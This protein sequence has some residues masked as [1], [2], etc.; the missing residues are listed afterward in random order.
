MTDDPS[1]WLCSQVQICIASVQGRRNS[2]CV[3]ETGPPPS[4]LGLSERGNRAHD[5]CYAHHHGQTSINAMFPPWQSA[6]WRRD[7]R[8]QAHKYPWPACRAPPRR[9][10]GG[11]QGANW[12]KA[13]AGGPM[14]SCWAHAP[15]HW[16]PITSLPDSGRTCRLSLLVLVCASPSSRLR[17]C[18]PVA[19]P[20][21]L[22]PLAHPQ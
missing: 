20:L 16:P 6:S 10:T 13:G 7:A 3:F 22:R 8:I 14:V 11:S 19:H 12:Q 9:S 4:V 18:I 5:V 17:V 15:Q 1:R 2:V 21:Y